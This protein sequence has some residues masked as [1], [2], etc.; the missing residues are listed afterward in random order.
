[1][2]VADQPLEATLRAVD[3]GHRRAARGELRR[4]AAGRGAE[5]DHALAR[6]IAE[7]PRRDRRRRI[8]D[9]PG[10]VGIARQGGDRAT[11]DAAQ[12]PGW[13]YRRLEQLAPAL[14]IA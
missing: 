8:L 6:D 13:Q 2:E 5:I 14:G 11:G 10:A 9:P 1:M 12:R 7:E 4:L 3:R